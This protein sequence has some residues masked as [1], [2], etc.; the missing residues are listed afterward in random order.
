MIYLFNYFKE[1]N[2]MTLI[3]RVIATEKVPTTIDSFAF[4][5][6]QI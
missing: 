1:D 2:N 5:L 4:G 3:G 6:I